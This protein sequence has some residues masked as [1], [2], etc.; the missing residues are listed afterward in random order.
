MNGLVYDDE[1]D[2]GDVEIRPIFHVV[3]SDDSMYDNVTVAPVDVFMHDNDLSP[4]PEG[5]IVG[6]AVGPTTETLA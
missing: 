6:I 4:L 2:E 3:S 5:F 1:I